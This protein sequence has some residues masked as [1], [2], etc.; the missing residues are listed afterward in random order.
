MR[1]L[2]NIFEKV[3]S[4]NDEFVRQAQN[5]TRVLKTEEWSF[6]VNAI[7]LI[8]GQMS[9]D[10]FSAKYTKMSES[11]KDVLQKTYCQTMLIL[12]FLA[13]PQGWI[14]KR[15]LYKQQ[16]ADHGKKTSSQMGGNSW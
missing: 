7:L 1:N 10:M 11:E 9:T 8:K 3:F 13:N 16:L 12:E 5:Y 4:S 6:L 2:V 14:N 15:A